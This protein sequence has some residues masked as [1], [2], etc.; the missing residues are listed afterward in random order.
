MD[1][2]QLPRLPTND[3]FVDQDEVDQYVLDTEEIADQ[4]KDEKT[5][6]SLYKRISR[7]KTVSELYFVPDIVFS[8]EE[9]ALCYIESPAAVFECVH[10]EQIQE[11]H[12]RGFEAFQSLEQ[13][14]LNQM[15]P[16]EALFGM[17]H[18]F[19]VDVKEFNKYCKKYHQEPFDYYK[20]V[21]DSLQQK[22]NLWLG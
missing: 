8:W 21:N 14:V 22:Y 1:P 10:Y 17:I 11:M 7:L 13:H 9:M 16:A 18:G 2:V 4:V 19:N 3:I 15:L 5:A 6:M 12:K 20:C